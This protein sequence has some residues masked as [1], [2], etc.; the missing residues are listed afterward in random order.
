MGIP[1][2]LIL[3]AVLLPLVFPLNHILRPWE[4]IVPAISNHH[5]IAE[6]RQGDKVSPFVPPLFPPPHNGILY[7]PFIPPRPLPSRWP[8]ASTPAPPDADVPLLGTISNPHNNQSHQSDNRYGQI[9]FIGVRHAVSGIRNTSVARSLIPTGYPYVILRS[10][11]RWGNW[12]HWGPG[13]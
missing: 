9:Y 12:G 10:I 4:N 3:L 5:Q 6:I 2:C 8:L 7:Y 1:V 13:K 11:V